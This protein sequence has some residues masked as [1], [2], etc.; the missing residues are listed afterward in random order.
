MDQVPPPRPFPARTRAVVLG[1]A[2]LALATLLLLLDAPDAVAGRGR[3]HIPPDKRT[4]GLGNSCQKDS[5]C[6]HKQQ[7]CLKEQDANGKQLQVGFCVLPC[8]A[9]DAGITQVIP[10]QPID[11]TPENVRDA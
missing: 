4:N 8:L 9:I 6:S 5:G 10:G 3:K 2:S 1:S 11:A 7:R